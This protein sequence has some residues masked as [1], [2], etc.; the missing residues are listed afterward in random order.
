MAKSSPHTFSLGVCR[1]TTTIECGSITVLT[2]SIANC[3]MLGQ[4]KTSERSDGAWRKRI[5]GEE[6]SMR[7]SGGKDDK[8][9]FKRKKKVGATPTRGR[10]YLEPKN[11]FL[12]LPGQSIAIMEN[13]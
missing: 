8:R 9:G 4:K 13:H 6:Q 3:G 12:L 5:A 11:F 2:N 10:E 1:L 7:P